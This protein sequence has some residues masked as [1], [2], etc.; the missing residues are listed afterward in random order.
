MTADCKFDADGIR[1]K[2]DNYVELGVDGLAVG[3]FI[4]ECWNASP[5]D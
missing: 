3:G 2:I 5:S 4:A 1:Y